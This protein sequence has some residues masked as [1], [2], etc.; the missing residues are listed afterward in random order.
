MMSNMQG[1]HTENKLKNI[2]KPR[3]FTVWQKSSMGFQGTDG[4]SV[5]DDSGRLAF[6]VDNYSRRQRFLTK[7]I[8]LMDGDGKALLCLRPRFLSL[9]DRWNAYEVEECENKQPNS[10]LFS[11]KRYSMLQNIDKAQVLLRNLADN[12]N[13]KLMPSFRIEGCFEKRSC[14]I[15]NSIGDEVAQ[16]S[17]KTTGETSVLLGNDVFSLVIQQEFDC[18]LV[19]AFIIVMDR[20]H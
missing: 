20:I 8:V 10:K 6:R 5:Y 18:K 9:H 3:V 11:M 17:R 14:K 7:E 16:I 4:F 2:D 12:N 1:Q 15:Y 19:M 13:P